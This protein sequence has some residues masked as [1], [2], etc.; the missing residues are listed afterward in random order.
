MELSG[1]KLSEVE[2]SF[3]VRTGVQHSEESF[4]SEAGGGGRGDQDLPRRSQEVIAECEK[5]AGGG[6]PPRGNQ[7]L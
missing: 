2:V 7:L 5:R 4:W 3:V 1:A 6:D